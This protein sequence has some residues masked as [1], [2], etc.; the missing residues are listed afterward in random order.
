[1]PVYLLDAC[2]LI[3]MFNNEEGAEKVRDLIFRSIQGEAGFFWLPAHPKN[4]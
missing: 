2:A 4:R 3:T 1:M